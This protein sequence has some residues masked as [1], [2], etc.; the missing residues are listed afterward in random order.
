MRDGLIE[1]EDREFQRWYDNLGTKYNVIFDLHDNWTPEFRRKFVNMEAKK[2][3]LGYV[4]KDG[5]VAVRDHELPYAG[6]SYRCYSKNIDDALHTFEDNW[7]REHEWRRAKFR[8]AVE[9]LFL[10]PS[11]DIEMAVEFMPVRIIYRPKRIRRIRV[12]TGT[13]LVTEL[14]ETLRSS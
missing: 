1:E 8:P 13:S 9:P 11:A 10:K 6:V 4:M 14:I 5:Y 3:G 7:N 2:R 12:S